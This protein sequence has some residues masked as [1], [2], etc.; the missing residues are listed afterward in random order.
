MKK[1]HFMPAFYSIERQWVVNWRSSSLWHDC[2]DYVKLNRLKLSE[3]KM[4]VVISWFRHRH[5]LNNNVR[6]DYNDNKML[7]IVMTITMIMLRKVIVMTMTIIFIHSGVRAPCLWLHQMVIWM[8]SIF[9]WIDKPR[10]MEW[11]Q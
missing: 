11:I 5:Y 2:A 6:G 7:I 9:Y 3:I 10:S 8:S 4:D 1:Q